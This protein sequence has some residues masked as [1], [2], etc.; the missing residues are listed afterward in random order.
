MFGVLKWKV[1]K[2]I[3]FSGQRLRKKSRFRVAG[4]TENISGWFRI[5]FE[6]LR[7]VSTE[8]GGT[9]KVFLKVRI[10]LVGECVEIWGSFW[11]RSRFSDADYTVMAFLVHIVT[12]KC[13][14]S[15][16]KA[17]FEKKCHKML[18]ITMKAESENW[19]FE[20]RDSLN[21]FKET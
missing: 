19:L 17:D 18:Y 9:N 11:R 20:L 13:L 21:C 4:A 1:E 16:F 3:Y 15:G 6:I 2:L 10:F 7:G 12:R 8:R 5:V 14:L